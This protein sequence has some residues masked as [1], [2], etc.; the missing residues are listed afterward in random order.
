MNKTLKAFIAILLAVLMIVATAFSTSAMQLL[1]KLFGGEH[2]ISIEVEPTDTIDPVKRKIYEI[3]GILPKN[4]KLTSYDHVS[5]EYTEL[6]NGKTLLDYG[7]DGKTGIYFEL[8]YDK[9]TAMGVDT[10]VSQNVILDFV[11]GDVDYKAVY[12]VDIMWN[13]LDFAYTDGSMAW[14]PLEHSYNV[15]TADAGWTDD[16]G[17]VTVDNHSN[18]AVNIDVIFEPA[19]EPN[20]TAIL[21]IENSSFPLASAVGTS[22]DEPPQGVAYIFAQGIPESDDSLGKITVAVNSTEHK[23]SW[24]DGTCTECGEACSHPEFVEGVC[25]VCGKDIFVQPTVA[26]VYSG[27]PDVSWF[28]EA[29][30]KSEYLLTTADQLVGLNQ[31]RKNSAGAVTFEGITVKLG[32]DMIINDGDMDAVIARG[33]S[34]KPWVAVSSAYTFNG[35]LDGQGHTVS[36]AFLKLGAAASQGILGSV[37]KNAEIKN[38][39]VINTLVTGPTDKDKTVLGT[40]VSKVSGDD[41][42]VKISNVTVH[43]TVKEAGY[44]TAQVGGIV[45][46]ISDGGTLTMDNCEFHGSVAITGRSAGGILGAANNTL[47]TVNMT[48]CKNYGDVTAKADA[49][50]LI[51]TSAIK[52]LNIEGSTN[53]GIVK[54]PVCQGE[55]VGYKSDAVDPRNG[56]RPE[57]TDIRVMS[58]NLQQDFNDFSTADSGDGTG[59]ERLKAIQQEIYFYAPDILGVQEDYAHVLE[60][61]SLTGYTKATTNEGNTN[62]S[63]CSIYYKNGMTLLRKGYRYTTSDNTKNTVALTAADVTTEGSRY[64]LTAAELKELGITKNT[65][66]NALKTSEGGVMLTTKVMT[67]ASFDV[68]GDVIIYANIHP[69]HRSQNASYSTPAVQ[70]LRTMERL[71]EIALAMKQVNAVKAARYADRNVHIIISGDYNDIVGSEPYLEMNKAHG[72]VSAHETALERYGVAGS[73]NNAFKL[74]YQG[75]NDKTVAERSS[76]NMLDFCFISS[77]LKA[78]KYRVGAGSAPISYQNSRYT[79]DHLPII[80]D[81][82]IGTELPTE[83]A[84]SVY[85]GTPDTS[86]YKEGTKTYT[87]TTADQFVGINKLRKDSAG[88][89]TFEGVT[90][91]LGADI[92][93]NEGTLANIKANGADNKTIVVTGTDAPFK[94][95]FDGQGHSISGVYLSTEYSYRSIFGTVGGSAQIKNFVL[96][97][98]Y[99]SI[100]NKPY[101]GAIVGRINDASANVSLT[102]ITL[103]DTVLLEEGS[104]GIKNVGGFV[105]ALNAGK[106]TVNNCHFNGTVNFPNGEHIAGFVG[107]ASGGTTIVFNNCHGTGKVIAK[108]YVAGLSVYADSTTKTNNGSCLTDSVACTTGSNKNASYIK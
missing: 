33:S 38:L 75:A 101:F 52:A 61:F 72:L 97:N 63:N 66:M 29:N 65:D 24:S 15:P 5:G 59:A 50:G 26:S 28:D 22:F 18:A 90:I 7:I 9:T 92:I 95:T 35:I 64:Q 8:Q 99:F 27:T 69:Q 21:V 40:L 103:A 53:S 89:I 68:N 74:A 42:N 20:G 13:N 45:G 102:N 43:S 58:F 57:E 76:F 96:E 108:D 105:G 77:G 3:E 80:T 6:M 51:G 49:G 48:N 73:W 83:K 11:S 54:S 47:A 55:L 23:H 98:S 60:K 100:S 4:Q 16:I 12:S 86:W 85:S 37:A 44:E 84:P 1:V 94:G 107:Q 81:I 19:D 2:T 17:K 41:A 25:S 62:S 88:A 104:S 67:W 39:N 79:S 87:L 93:I 31:I 56:L 10:T 32:A 82:K 91:K 78:L 30:P 34:N 14:N 106:L 71:K 36:G 70:K 46:A